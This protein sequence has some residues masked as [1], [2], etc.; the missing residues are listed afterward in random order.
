MKVHNYI[1]NIA[2]NKPNIWFRYLIVYGSFAGSGTGCSK[3]AGYLVHCSG[4][5]VCP[6]Q[7]DS[8]MPLV[9]LTVKCSSLVSSTHFSDNTV[10]R[11]SCD[12]KA[13]KQKNAKFQEVIHLFRKVLN[14]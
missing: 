10:D 8:N 2:S 9:V 11:E 14:L 7:V 4:Y 3:T 6:Y 12:K 13:K 1:C 5:P